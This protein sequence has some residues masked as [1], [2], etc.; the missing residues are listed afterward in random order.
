MIKKLMLS[1]ALTISVS[2]NVYEPDLVAQGF[3][4]YRQGNYTKA[5]KLF[6]K[7]CDED[8]SA[9]CGMVGAYYEDGNEVEVNFDIALEYYKKACTM[10]D[11]MGCKHSKRIESLQ[12]M[13]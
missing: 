13:R 4:E 9:G 8:Y 7:A 2:A 5:F 6:K 10:G 3:A 11:V 12:S 1:I